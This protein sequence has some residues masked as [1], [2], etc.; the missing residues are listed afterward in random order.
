MSVAPADLPLAWPAKLSEGPVTLRPIRLRDKRRWTAVRESNQSWL[1]PWDATTPEGSAAGPGN[2]GSYVRG[3][4][5]QARAG[6]AW[7]WVIEYQGALVGQLTVGGIARGAALSGT[8]GYWVA[9]EVAGRE[10]APTAVALAFDHAI[11][12]G[13][14]HRLEIAINPANGPSLRVAEK[15]GFRDEGLRLRFL[16]VAGAWRDHRAFALTRED[17]PDGLMSRWR[18]VRRDQT[19]DASH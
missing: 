14:L 4:L 8:A 9:H 16:H 2:F 15:L 1:E 19:A 5:R 11:T 3:L 17:V 6:E 7:P 18:Q 13:G 10:I 12:A